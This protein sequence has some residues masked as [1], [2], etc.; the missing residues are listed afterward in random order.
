MKLDLFA[1]ARQKQTASGTVAVHALPRI[2]AARPDDVLT[3]TARGSMNGRHGAPRLDLDV[4][5]SVTLI[6]QRC[7]QPLQEPIAIRARFLIAADEATADALDQD[8]DYD[9]VVGATDFEVDTL[10]EDE[11]ILALPGAPRHRVCP[12]GATDGSDR[13]KK[14]SPFAVLAGLRTGSPGKPDTTGR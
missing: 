5:G 12:D 14:P 11:V 13:T 4:D 6:C 1:F 3:W 7:L 2:D 10:V 8:D 9:V